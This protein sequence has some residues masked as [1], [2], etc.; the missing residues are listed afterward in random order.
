MSNISTRGIKFLSQKGVP[1]EVVEYE[2]VEKGAAYASEAMG[3]PLEKTIKTLVVD[4]GQK[5]YVLALVPGSATLDLKTLA[6]QLGV[7]RAQM[8]DTSTAERVTGYL[9]GGI[10]PFGTK[11]RLKAIMDKRLL[12]F[13]KVAINGGKRGTMVILDPKDIVRVIDCD[14]L[15]ITHDF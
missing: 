6:K 14:T 11:A 12:A 5:G 13:D 3:F 7:K 2:H 4:I 8:A 15:P 10:S 1:F 9:V